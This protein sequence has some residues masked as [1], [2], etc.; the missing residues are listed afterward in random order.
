MREGCQGGSVFFF[1]HLL[2]KERFRSFQLPYCQVIC[3][4]RM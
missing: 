4:F 2:S 1:L 3:V